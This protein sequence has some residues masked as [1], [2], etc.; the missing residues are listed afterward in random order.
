MSGSRLRTL[1]KGKPI[2]TATS[3]S[4]SGVAFASVACVRASKE[5]AGASRSGEGIGRQS[6]RK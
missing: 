4:G 1:A 5:V 2:G 3:T 6:C